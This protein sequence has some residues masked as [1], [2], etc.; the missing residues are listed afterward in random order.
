MRVKSLDSRK[1]DAPPPK[2]AG[3][4]H[5]VPIAGPGATLGRFL[6]LALANIL[7]NLMVPLAGLIDTAFLG[8][9]AAIHHLG[10]VALATV[11][12]NMVYWSFGFL[13]MGTTGT[14]AQ[15]RG[16][17]HEADLWLILLRHGSVALGSG[18]LILVLQVPLREVGFSLLQ[19]DTAV[20]AAGYAFYNKLMC[21]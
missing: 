10:G 13:R 17:G 14:T 8:H 11:I 12:F 3:S 18:I 19:G 1:T 16:R 20:K 6:R 21:I 4:A 5:E 7:S 9:L 2:G 15:A